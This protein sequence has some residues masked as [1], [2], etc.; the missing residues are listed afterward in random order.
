MKIKLN[1]LK[2]VL[3]SGPKNYSDTCKCLNAIALV[4]KPVSQYQSKWHLF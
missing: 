4:I 3:L 1:F 2:N